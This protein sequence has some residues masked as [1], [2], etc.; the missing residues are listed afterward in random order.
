MTVTNHMIRT[1]NHGL[2][3]E[4]TENDDGM[5][6]IGF[7]VEGQPG[8]LQI[9]MFCPADGS[10][11]TVSITAEGEFKPTADAFMEMLSLMALMT[12]RR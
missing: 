4:L 2:T 5:S 8:A 6:R 3:V 11:P 7:S 1:F 12:E 10:E 9:A